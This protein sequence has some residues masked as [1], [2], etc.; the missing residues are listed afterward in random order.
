[1]RIQGH[2]I[3]SELHNSQSLLYRQ[4]SNVTEKDEISD[5]SKILFRDNHQPVLYQVLDQKNTAHIQCLHNYYRAGSRSIIICPLKQGK[6]LLGLL[7]ISSHEPGYLQPFH[8]SKIEPAV[9]LF[10]ISLEKSLEQLNSQVEELIKKKFTAVQPAVE[11]K[12]TE[13]S[14]NYLVSHYKQSDT[15]LER[16]VFEQ[17]YPFFGAIDV[18]NSSTARSKAVQADL[19]EQLELAAVVIRK[20]QQE[21]S[22]PILYEL[23]NKIEK[24]KSAVAE[25]LRS[26]EEMAVYDFL[27]GQLLAVFNHLLETEPAVKVETETY[28]ASLDPQ[29]QYLYRHRKEYEQ[30]IARINETLARFVDREQQAAQK[31]YPHY[32]ERFITDGLEFN[33]FMGQ[34]ISPRKKMDEIYLRNLK[35][36]QLTMM[37]K[38]AR[39]TAQLEQEL[40][41]PLRT[42][43]LILASNQPLTICFRTEERKFDVDG[44]GNTRYEII[45]KRIDK[46]HIRNSDERLTQ[47]GMVAI[48]YTQAKDATEYKEY[49]EFLQHKE[50]LQPG[51][52]SLDL[53]ELQGVSGLKALRV[54]IRPDLPGTLAVI[55]KETKLVVE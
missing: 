51:I 24:Y 17:V 19:L 54:A 44:V 4:C 31:I 18:R 7:E 49:I 12:F 30:S 10:K 35:M 55:A 38:A 6:E 43:Q 48:V 1:F 15:R 25:T 52:E 34:S 50:L 23:L 37:V 8:I 14:L 13:V 16:I 26:N 3:Y 42:T 27:Q 22:F 9:P 47:P 20:A 46:V 33:M 29:R 28:F 2:Y 39:V 40:P 21:Q 45:K 53:E 36:W 32:F 41:M 5:Y 11:W